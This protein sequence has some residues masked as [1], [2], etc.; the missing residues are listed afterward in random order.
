[1]SIKER[2]KNLQDHPRIRDL[3]YDGGTI[4]IFVMTVA[5]GVV[6]GTIFDVTDKI[7]E[8]RCR[9]EKSSSS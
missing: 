7:K 5:T 4:I 9:K 6:I 2:L 3:L 8:R 1:M